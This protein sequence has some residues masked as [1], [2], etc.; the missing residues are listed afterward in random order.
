MQE[1]RSQVT[2][3][4][5]H[6]CRI[7]NKCAWFLQVGAKYTDAVPGARAKFDFVKVIDAQY[8]EAHDAHPAKEDL[9]QTICWN[10]YLEGA[11]EDAEDIV[12]DDEMQVAGGEFKNIKCVLSQKG[13][14]E[15][16]DPVEDAN[17]WI[18]ERAVIEEYI[19]QRGGRCQNPAAAAGVIITLAEL[20][21]ARKV[22]R[23]KFKASQRQTATREEGFE[24]L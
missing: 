16:A 11:G 1:G 23:E 14:F 3:C 22:M 8:K 24:V 7:F 9:K 6:G 17:K 12:D 4:W 13:I 5:P 15:L 2:T 10:A 20:K 21:P 18:W 19:Q